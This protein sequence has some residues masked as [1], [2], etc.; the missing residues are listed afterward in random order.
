MEQHRKRPG[1]GTSGTSP[2]PGPCHAEAAQ[3][4]THATTAA[5]ACGLWAWPPPSGMPD[6]D[7]LNATAT[8]HHDGHPKS[9]FRSMRTTL[10]PVPPT[11]PETCR[12]RMPRPGTPGA[13]SRTTSRTPYTGRFCGRRDYLMPTPPLPP[14]RN[15]PQTPAF[16]CLLT[17]ASEAPSPHPAGMRKALW[18]RHRHH[19][20][21]QHAPAPA[22]TLPVP[23]GHHHHAHRHRRSPVSALLPARPASG[24]TPMPCSG[25]WLL[26]Y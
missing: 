3:R 5:P 20:H 1:I 7:R 16:P 8:D 26:L 19:P 13:E 2:A 4:S 24:K 10:K 22:A 12:T 15:R 11:D 18:N 9:P 6:A 25:T 21:P 17:P 23:A 14:E